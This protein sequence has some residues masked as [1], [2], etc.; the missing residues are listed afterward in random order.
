MIRLAALMAMIAG[1]AAASCSDDAVTVKGDWG[2][3]RFAVTVA[4]EPDERS[5]GLMFV[6]DMPTMKGMFFVYEEPRH[7]TFWMK[8]TLIPLDMIFA[9]KMGRVTR[10]HPDA[11]PLDETVIDGGQDVLAVLEINGGLA[12]RL[13]IK[14]GNLLQHPSFGADAVLPCP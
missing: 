7:A 14:V 9:D 4:D 2:Q 10:V 6:E 12:A 5:Q 8:N 13:G 3:A 11:K 1:Q